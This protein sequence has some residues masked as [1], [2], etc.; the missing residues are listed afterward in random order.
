MSNVYEK[1]NNVWKST[2]KI[3]FRQEIGDGFPGTVK[4]FIYFFLHIQRLG[5]KGFN[6]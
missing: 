4:G 3:L 5:I 1:V 6:P 2:C